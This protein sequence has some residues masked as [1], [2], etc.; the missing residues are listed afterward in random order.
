MDI[1]TDITTKICRYLDSLAGCFYYKAHGGGFSKRGIPDIIVCYKGH[2]IGIE[3]KTPKGV[4]SNTQR[5]IGTR[6]SRAGGIYFVA[7]CVDDVK[8][9][10]T[11]L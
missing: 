5:Y 3:S 4:L 6:I 7:R 2:Y 9:V 8:A 1:E 10:L 11:R